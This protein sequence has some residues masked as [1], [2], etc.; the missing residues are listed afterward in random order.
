MKGRY[1]WGS[2]RKQGKTWQTTGR[3]L[4]V[5]FGTVW[6]GSKVELV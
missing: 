1:G 4:R 6:E 5:N 3:D 2:K